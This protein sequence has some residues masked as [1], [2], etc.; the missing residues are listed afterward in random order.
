[1]DSSKHA[2]H[3]YKIKN[4]QKFWKWKRKFWQQ[5]NFYSTKKKYK[6]L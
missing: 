3:S 1:M 5:K 4:K 6:K 2:L